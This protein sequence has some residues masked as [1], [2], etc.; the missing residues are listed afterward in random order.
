VGSKSLVTI[1]QSRYSVPV[2][3]AGLPV[4]AR[5]GAREISCH[6]G[7]VIWSRV[8]SVRGAASVSLPR[9]ITTSSCSPAV[10]AGERLTPLCRL[11]FDP[12]GWWRRRPGCW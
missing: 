8:T 11:R 3:L 5:V 12:L 9:S 4:R 7:A 6:H 2:R 10:G 1:K